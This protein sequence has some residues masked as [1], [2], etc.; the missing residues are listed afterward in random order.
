MAQMGNSAMELWNQVWGGDWA[1]A[2]G[3]SRALGRVCRKIADQDSNGRWASQARTIALVAQND[4]LAAVRLWHQ[5]A[6]TVRDSGRREL[7]TQL[8]ENHVLATSR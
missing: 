7:T 4:L 3:D 8:R 5:F 1:C 6:A 2:M